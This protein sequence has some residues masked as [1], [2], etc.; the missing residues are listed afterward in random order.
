MHK[1]RIATCLVAAAVALAPTAA[2]DNSLVQLIRVV[3]GEV[4]TA[5]CTTLG[6]ALR[7]SGLANA[8][9]T[10]SELVAKVNGAVGTDSTL[11]LATAP[12]VNK[13]ADRAV[14]CGVVKPDPVTPQAQAIAFVSELSS[15][16][17][18]PELR[19]LLP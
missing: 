7:V 14:A 3:N 18:L 4:E 9:T 13:L 15:R 1:T 10:R 17:G 19:N 11:R 8:E 16:A 6:T 12:T 5:D 2:A